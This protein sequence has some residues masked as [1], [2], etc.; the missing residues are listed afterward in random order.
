MISFP[1]SFTCRREDLSSAG[2]FTALPMNAWSKCR[3]K[4]AV[5]SFFS[6]KYG[7][8]VQHNQYTS[9]ESV[10]LVASAEPVVLDED[11][12]IQTADAEPMLAK[13][14]FSTL[15]RLKTGSRTSMA[16]ARLN[17]LTSAY[18]HKPTE[19]DS[20]SVL[21]R[22]DASGHRRIALAFSKE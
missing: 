13:R 7:D 6:E 21:K 11:Y 22:W 2:K 10:N 5:T 4:K 1:L 16:N 8:H 3:D 15:R 17:G 14:S 9:S 20:S 19:I 18:I 12:S